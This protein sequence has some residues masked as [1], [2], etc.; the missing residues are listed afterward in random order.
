MTLIELH[1]SCPLLCFSFL[2]KCVQNICLYS[3]LTVFC[4]ADKQSN[5]TGGKKNKNENENCRKGKANSSKC[6]EMKEAL[7]DDKE[8]SHIDGNQ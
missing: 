7:R 6:T 8:I 5:Y 2:A 4:S 1:A 3:M